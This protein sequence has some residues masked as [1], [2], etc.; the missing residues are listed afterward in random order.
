M[1]QE[2]VN[3]VDSIREGP[4]APPPAAA[5]G[6]VQRDLAWR[7]RQLAHAGVAHAQRLVL[8]R[9]RLEDPRAAFEL[10]RETSQRYNVKL[11]ILADALVH[12]PGPPTGSRSW[13][14]RRPLPAPPSVPGLGADSSR[15]QHGAVL[16]AALRRA[17]EIAQASMGNVQL[18][19]NGLLR[20]EKHAGLSREFT[21]FFAFVEHSTTACAQ[22]AEN[23]RQITVKDV[24]F[25]DA[26]DEDSRATIL[27]AG[28]RACHS[29]PLLS[30]KGT[31]LGVMSTHHER[32]LNGL[33][34]AQLATLDDLATTVGRWLIWHRHTVVLTA[35]EGLH[36]TAL[37]AAG[38]R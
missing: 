22:A 31:V 17:L 26:F 16:N 20:L 5:G 3:L 8:D 7:N 37:H 9:Y 13:F 15:A 2:H 18:A 6:S 21:D 10:L 30:P 32:P 12:V 34:D 29:I 28:S 25:S 23:R 36:V 1:H 38:P 24:A 4:A 35:L 11:H 14:P 33:T 27:E 19:E